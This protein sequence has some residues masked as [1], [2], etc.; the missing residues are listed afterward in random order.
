MCGIFGLITNNLGKYPRSLIQ[1]H[2][3]R[4][5]LLSESRGSEAAGLAAKANSYIY[6]FKK[7]VTPSN[8]I[9]SEGC[10]RAATGISWTHK[11]VT[12]QFH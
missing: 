2:V 3:T 4:L 7:A 9:D 11:M 6:V 12:R 1:N 8:L 10:A 5:F